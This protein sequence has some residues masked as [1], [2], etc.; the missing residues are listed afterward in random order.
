MSKIKH[1]ER[2]NKY[3]KNGSVVVVQPA[4]FKSEAGK[5]PPLLPFSVYKDY[6]YPN[7]YNNAFRKSIIARDNNRCQVCRLPGTNK[8]IL[9]VHHINYDKRDCSETNLLTLCIRC[10]KKTNYHRF[11]WYTMLRQ[12]MRQTVILVKTIKSVVNSKRVKAQQ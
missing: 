8:R 5:S 6:K 2:F 11:V 1:A 10:H 12:Q 7:T 4:R 9:A 3:A